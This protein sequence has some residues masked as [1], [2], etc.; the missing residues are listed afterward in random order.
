M[1]THHL[2][3][4]HG[5]EFYNDVPVFYSLGNFIFSHDIVEPDAEWRTY[6]AY[7]WTNLQQ[8]L[9]NIGASSNV[10]WTGGK[11]ASCSLVPVTVAEDAM[12][13]HSAADDAELLPSRLKELSQCRGTAF[14]LKKLESGFEITTDKM[15]RDEC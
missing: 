6:P 13:L 3:V 5:V 7:S 15:S 4:V 11:L 2:H 9:S 10:S 1:F 8:T 14:E 12:P